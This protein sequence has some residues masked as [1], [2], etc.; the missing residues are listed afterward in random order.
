MSDWTTLEF[1]VED[2]ED[3]RTSEIIG[4][5]T[6]GYFVHGVFN[7]NNGV[8]VIPQPDGQET[9]LIYSQGHCMVVKRKEALNRLGVPKA[10]QAIL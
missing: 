1:W 10:L 8:C 4:K 6:N 7:N 9:V 5:E 2:L 3:V